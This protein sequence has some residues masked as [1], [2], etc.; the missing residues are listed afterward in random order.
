MMR[1]GRSARKRQRNCKKRGRL[2]L[3]ASKD[4]RF[5]LLR[6][7]TTWCLIVSR[8]SFVGFVA[9]DA[10]ASISFHSSNTPSNGCRSDRRLPKTNV[11]ERRFRY[12]I[13]KLR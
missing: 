1:A 3:G 7:V 10:L 6:K 4:K 5:D 8:A 2:G 9:T 13:I 11:P 12:V